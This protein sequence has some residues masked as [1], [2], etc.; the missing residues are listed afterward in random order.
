MAL[1]CWVQRRTMVAAIAASLAQPALAQPPLATAVQGP[2]N[3]RATELFARDAELN[4]WAVRIYDA[5]RDGWLTLY[6][7]QPALAAFRDIADAD[8]DGRVTVREYAEAKVFIEA[9]Y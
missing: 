4:R 6:E 1:R 9:R 2:V 8:R 3:P 7:A 5:N